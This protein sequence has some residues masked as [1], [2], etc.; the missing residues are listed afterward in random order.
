MVAIERNPG[1][2]DD[3]RDAFAR[4]APISP[5]PESSLAF[6][7][8]WLRKKPSSLEFDIDASLPPMSLSA[9][10][11]DRWQCLSVLLAFSHLG[12]DPDGRWTTLRSWVDAPLHALAEEDR[13]RMIA[14]VIRLLETSDEHA[15][16]QLAPWLVREG[17]DD[18]RQV[19]GAP[20]RLARR[21]PRSPEGGP[22]PAGRGPHGRDPARSQ[23]SFGPGVPD[24]G[25][26]DSPPGAS[27]GMIFG[28][29]CDASLKSRSRAH[30]SKERKTARGRGRPGRDE[31][32]GGGR[33]RA[34]NEILGRA[35]RPTPAKEGGAAILAAIVACVDEALAEAGRGRGRHRGASAS[36]R[37]ARSTPRPA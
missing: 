29:P 36:A 2:V 21:D 35:K 14:W 33:R 26:I 9:E 25:P 8:N 7:Q 1:A 32:P 13:Y 12:I 30:G 4:T 11:Q 3:L 28:N 18:A 17:V 15:I 34:D 5:I 19:M 6:V 20:G 37:P 10:G 22:C 16:V 31:D 27:R 24:S 23:R